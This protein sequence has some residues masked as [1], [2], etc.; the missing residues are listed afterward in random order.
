MLDLRTF[1][2]AIFVPAMAVPI[3][4]M[5]A[6][7]IWR[8][9]ARADGRWSGAPLI[10]LGF[11]L[12]FWQVRGAPGWPLTDVTN[13]FFWIAILLIPLGVLDAYIRPP[14]WARS[15]ILVLLWRMAVRALLAPLIPRAISGAA[16]E[17]WLDLLSL[18]MLAWWLG[19]ETLAERLPGVATPMV[20]TLTAIGTAAT[21]GFWQIL[22][23]AAL[24]GAIAVM[25]GGATVAVLAHPRIAVSRGLTMAAVLLLQLLLIH[26]YFYTD[27]PIDAATRWRLAL[28]I[29]AP[30]GA[31][32]G[33]FGYPR[34]WR[35]GRLLMRLLPVAIAIAASVAWAA[36]SFR[37]S[38]A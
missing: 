2:L 9:P 27:A 37:R 16:V 6:W 24:A 21:L 28:L 31:F 18:T 1:V 26:G 34:R 4:M 12:A 17:Y 29:V 15:I 10:V 25:C 5:L 20:L 8:A 13:W 11:G 19:L 32:A 14:L 30:L 33:D 38:D 22:T 23:S 3:G 35:S 7:R 36:V